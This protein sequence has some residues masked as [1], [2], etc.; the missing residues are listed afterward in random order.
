M[1]FIFFLNLTQGATIESQS[2]NH[3]VVTVIIK[4][5]YNCFQ[6]TKIYR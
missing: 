2:T 1:T 6:Y 5:C 4:P 3:I